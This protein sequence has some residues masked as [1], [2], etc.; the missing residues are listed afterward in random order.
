[1]LPK[2]SGIQCAANFRTALE[3]R[4]VP[5]AQERAGV[6]RSGEHRA[7]VH[8]LGH[9]HLPPLRMAG[10]TVN[11]A[12]AIT[13]IQVIQPE[14]QAESQ[15][16]RQSDVLVAEL[17]RREPASCAMLRPGPLGPRNRLPTTFSPGHTVWAMRAS[18]TATWGDAA[19][20]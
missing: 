16:L 10:G 17:L 5:P 9:G 20:S 13:A 2:P 14:D 8:E 1:M 19:S 15:L 12:R 6:R 11:T 18:T 7:N 4:L 3:L